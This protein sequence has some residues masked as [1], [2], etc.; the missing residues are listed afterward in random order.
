MTTFLKSLV[1]E[2]TSKS[3]SD[4]ASFLKRGGK[5]VGKKTFQI[6]AQNRNILIPLS[7]PKN[8]QLLTDAEIKAKFCKKGAA[9]P[10]RRSP[11]RRKTHLD[12]ITE[13]R[14]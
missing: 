13:R 10:R 1:S 5:A 14:G 4:T 12:R 9:A 8:P 11:V 3:L 2:G 6:L 7:D